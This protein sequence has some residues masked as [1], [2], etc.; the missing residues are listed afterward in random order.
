MIL[1]GFCPLQQFVCDGTILHGPGEHEGGRGNA[2]AGELLNDLLQMRHR[3]GNHF[4]DDTVSPGHF[5]A[6]QNLRNLAGLGSDT[7]ATLSHKAAQAKNGEDRQTQ[8][9]QIDLGMVAGN[10]ARFLHL[11]HTLGN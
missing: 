5:I 2:K 3:G 6:F 7:S 10:K 1:R 8:L 11:P 4:D 9:G